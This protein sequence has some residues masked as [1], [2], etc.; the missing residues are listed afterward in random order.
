MSLTYFYIIFIFCLDVKSVY[1]KCMSYAG[2]Y[3]DFQELC[4]QTLFNNDYF[5]T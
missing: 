3:M 4:L 2:D 1:N 5:W